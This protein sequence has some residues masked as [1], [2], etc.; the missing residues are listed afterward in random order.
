M[1]G[2]VWEVERLMLVDEDE[3]LRGRDGTWKGWSGKEADIGFC[4]GIFLYVLFEGMME[5]IE[6][7]WSKMEG[8]WSSEPWKS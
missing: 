2:L 8:K 4:R 7:A 1:V 5:F 6:M 3:F